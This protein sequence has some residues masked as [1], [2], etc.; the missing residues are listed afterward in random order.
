[1]VPE[2]GSLYGGDRHRLR[3]GPVQVISSTIPDAEAAPRYTLLREDPL[4][5]A[6][7]ETVLL[8]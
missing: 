5:R 6:L 4:R 8:F 3:L 7:G 2:I 1:M